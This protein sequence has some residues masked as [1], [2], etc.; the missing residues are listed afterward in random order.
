[1]AFNPGNPPPP[2]S[3]PNNPPPPG[4]SQ[5]PPPGHTFD[6]D[7][8][9]LIHD[10]LNHVGPDQLRNDFTTAISAFKMQF[11]SADHVSGS[12]LNFVDIHQPVITPHH[13]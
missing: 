3:V 12:G 6:Q 10:A 4:G 9:N 5:A 1:M 13:S 2:G 7:I 11:I 8:T